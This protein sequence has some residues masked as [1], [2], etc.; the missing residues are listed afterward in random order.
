MRCNFWGLLFLGVLLAAHSLTAGNVAHGADITA[1]PASLGFP[2]GTADVSTQSVLLRAARPGSVTIESVHIESVSGPDD[3]RLDASAVEIVDFTPGSSGSTIPLKIK[4]TRS[5]FGRSGSYKIVLRVKGQRSDAPSTAQ[6]TPPATP[7]DDALELSLTR[8][9]AQLTVGIPS[10]A[11]VIVDR[12]FPWNTG[13]QQVPISVNQD[14]GPDIGDLKFK[15]SAIVRSSDNVLV[16]GAVSINPAELKIASGSRGSGMLVLDGLQRAGDFKTELTFTAPGLAKSVSVPIS[17]WV[18][19]GWFLPLLVII[20]GVLAGSLVHYLARIWRPRQLSAYRLTNLQVRL[21]SLAIAIGGTATR[22]EYSQLTV[23]L[24]NLIDGIEI[25]QTTDALIQQLETDVTAL[26]KQLATTDAAASD[27]LKKLQQDLD[28]ATRDLTLYGGSAKQE[29]DGIQAELERCSQTHNAGHAEEA[30]DCVNQIKDTFVIARGRL[31]RAAIEAMKPDIA[32]VTDPKRAELTTKAEQAATKIVAADAD[33]GQIL[34]DLRQSI[35]TALQMPSDAVA[36]AIVIRYGIK[37]TP[38]PANR[39]AGSPIQFEIDP[40]PSKPIRTVRWTIDGSYNPGRTVRMTHNHAIPGDFT[41]GAEIVYQDGTSDSVAP[42]RVTALPGEAV[43]RI[44]EILSG[45]QRVD[46]GLLA[47]AI[48]VAAIT[49]LLD[50]YVDKP[51]GTIGDYCWAFLWG[52]GIDSVVKGFATT[53]T[54]I[55]S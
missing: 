44:R 48:I 45:I 25:D 40:T 46:M 28:K 42:L 17:I 5:A 13:A 54:K 16:P 6:P 30:L 49:G 12:D 19:D 3:V 41:V 27:A 55:K 37:A 29:L 20:A 47:I 36:P 38:N 18:R 39:R 33:I 14:S 22:R 50:R 10:G 1:L 31:A 11:R 53:F 51:F 7:V 32:S 21:E 26:H 24:R 52:F 2:A 8:A 15:P 43:G 34:A 35:D 9:P 4:L 23:R